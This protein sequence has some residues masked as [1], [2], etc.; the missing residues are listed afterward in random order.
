MA[1]GEVMIIAMAT[2]MDLHEGR[3]TTTPI[4]LLLSP[5]KNT[6]SRRVP[7]PRTN[8]LFC[9]RWI[10]FHVLVQYGVAF[11][12]SDFFFVILPDERQRR[13]LE[14]A[15]AGSAR[16]TKRDPHGDPIQVRTTNQRLDLVVSSMYV[17]TYWTEYW[18]AVAALAC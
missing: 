1:N 18:T 4:T 8:A 10:S 7:P 6:H 14:R 9:S 17:R 3:A 12:I 13:Q 2:V 5:D 16:R 15:V 11:L